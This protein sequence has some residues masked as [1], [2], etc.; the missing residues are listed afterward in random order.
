MGLFDS[1]GGFISGL[2]NYNYT[3]PKI[4]PGDNPEPRSVVVFPAESKKWEGIVWH[5]SYSKDN[6]DRDEWVGII[7]YHTSYRIDGDIVTKEVF[8]KRQLAKDGKSFEK[9]WSD[10]GYHGGVERANGGDLVWRQG[11]P[12]TKAGAH[13]GHPGNNMFNDKYLG[14][15]CVGNFDLSAPD[16]ETWEFCLKATRDIMKT[17]GIPKDKVLGHRETYG[18]VGL[19]PAKT[20]PGSKWDMNAFRAAL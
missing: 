12:W 14:L 15:C 6:P 2:R 13:A 19:P 3:P 16:P 7:R 11:R 1:I 8:E 18:M 4:R 17:F 10:V 5:H 20:C 9:P